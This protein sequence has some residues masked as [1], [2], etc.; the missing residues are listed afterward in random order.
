MRL[1]REAAGSGCDDQRI[2]TK[3]ERL[4]RLLALAAAAVLATARPAEAYPQFQLSQGADT[5][6]QCHFSPGGGGLLNA[7]GRDE[8]GSTLST[9][10]GSGGF[11]HGAW[12]PPEAFQ[13][14]ADLRFLGGYRR[15]AAVAEPIYFPMQ[16]EVYL[17][18][19]VGPVS[20]YVA[21]G[22][23]PARSGFSVASREH[24]LLYE[25]EEA[26]WYVRAGRFYPVFGIRSQDHTA[27]PRRHLQMYLYEEPYGVAWGR[28][29]ADSELH[30]SAF[31]V[32]P[33]ALG[34]NQSSGVAAYWERR[35][36]GGTAA[37]ALQTR[38]SASATDR[39][40]WLGALYKRWLPGPRL[41]L[42]A[43]ADAGV[44]AFADTDQGPRLQAL[45]SLGA[46]YFA[47][48]GL[49]VGGTLQAFDP[50]LRLRASGR[51]A[52]QVD[53]QWLP[54]P[55]LELHLLVRGEV[56]GL[57]LDEPGLLI[58]AQLHYYL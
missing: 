18:P 19:Q 35:D 27:Y 34:T 26:T 42:L 57:A 5:C 23:R 7:Y 30:L 17:R 4:L 8:A 10:D 46:T 39:R 48:R 51:H 55:H 43:E 12:D 40:G 6:R 33:P 50:D 49:L 56:V 41:M 52:A 38:L 11:A 21:G 36:A 9:W 1:S 3:V 24:F 32:S 14:G 28:F 29:G 20:L 31:T 58:A 15:D 25:P 53:V 2:R 45:G 22:L 37:Y 44:Q 16:L 13:L 47:A 54:I